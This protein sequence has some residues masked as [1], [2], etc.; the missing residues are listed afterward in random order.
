M[1]ELELNRL[2]KMFGLRAA[3]PSK[4]ELRKAALFAHVRTALPHTVDTTSLD[5]IESL[6]KLKKDCWPIHLETYVGA[7]CSAQHLTKSVRDE[8][9]D[10]LDDIPIE[11]PSASALM[12]TILWA[13]MA[14]IATVMWIAGPRETWVMIVSALAATGLGVA[15]ASR[16][17]SLP[18]PK[19]N[20]AARH[21]ERYAYIALAGVSAA[22]ILPAMTGIVTLSSLMLSQADFSRQR[23][24][25]EADPMGFRMIQAFAMRNF[26][27]SLVLGSA[28]SGWLATAQMLPGASGAS[29]HVGAGYCELNADPRLIVSDFNQNGRPRNSL[30]IQGILIHELGHCLDVS[31]DFSP[32]GQPLN[33]AKLSVAPGDRA[34]M[35]SIDALA[36]NVS[37]PST[38]LWREALSDIMAVGYWRTVDEDATKKMIVALEEKRRSST[39]DRAHATM[40]WIRFAA[41]ATLPARQ[42][43]LFAWA[44][45]TRSA[46]P[47]DPSRRQD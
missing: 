28:D 34:I 18:I 39:H 19:R 47:C 5:E 20:N 6:A 36:G 10:E 29:V 32:F 3:L 27:T 14:C 40:C 17:A 21:R 7:M 42:S 35:G 13:A 46:A 38:A 8:I 12:F 33:P 37:V 25:F 2:R 30:W 45:K 31:R 44:D 1:R 15:G 11:G 41:V 9:L 22:A 4:F 24:A 16:S 43:E 26:N 23:D